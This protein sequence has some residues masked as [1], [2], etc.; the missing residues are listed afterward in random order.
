MKTMINR[1]SEKLVQ[2]K[3]YV[4]SQKKIELLPKNKKNL[5]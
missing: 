1:C 5:F 3:F 2:Q 4:Q